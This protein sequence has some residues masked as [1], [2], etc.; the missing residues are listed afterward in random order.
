MP[1][2]KE[3]S[4]ASAQEMSGA[5]LQ[6]KVWLLGLSPMVWRRV[7]VPATFT[8]RQ[9]HGVIQVAMGWEGAHLF[10]FQ[11]RAI[12]YGS[13]ELSARSPEVTIESKASGETPRPMTWAWIGSLGRGALLTRTTEPPRRRNPTSASE[14]GRNDSRPLCSTPQMSHRMAS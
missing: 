14:A 5:I 12:R 4:P 2:R 10:Q 13:S 3:L 9:F 7:Q 11:L 6:F 1:R 8:L